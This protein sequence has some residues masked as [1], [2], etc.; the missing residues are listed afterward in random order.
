[1][2]KKDSASANQSLS[3]VKL[4]P[5]KSGIAVL[6]E[7]VTRILKQYYR[8]T[9]TEAILNELIKQL[10]KKVDSLSYDDLER[11]ATALLQDQETSA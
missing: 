6:R 4:P 5:T 3:E 7:E 9:E 11:L 10:R 8:P 2:V 1:M